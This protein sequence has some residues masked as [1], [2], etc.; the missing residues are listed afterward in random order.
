[1]LVHKKRKKFTTEVINESI[2]DQNKMES[3]HNTTERIA[4]ELAMEIVHSEQGHYEPVYQ[5]MLKKVNSIHNLALSQV[6]EK[7]PEI[8][9]EECIDCENE[10]VSGEGV[11]YGYTETKNQAIRET[12]DKVKSIIT[13]LQNE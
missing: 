13:S 8:D 2:K 4:E 11:C 3:T 10:R 1:M 12:K 7:L 6:L 9:I 5:R